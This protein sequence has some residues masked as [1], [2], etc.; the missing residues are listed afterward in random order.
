MEALPTLILRGLFEEY[1]AMIGWLQNKRPAVTPVTFRKLTKFCLEQQCTA[2]Q[3]ISLQRMEVRA[4]CVANPEY[5][6]NPKLKGVQ[7]RSGWVNRL[8]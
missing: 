2:A 8:C 5:A 1:Y 6:F 7:P 4:R 3:F